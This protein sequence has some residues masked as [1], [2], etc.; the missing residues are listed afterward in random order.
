MTE[1]KSPPPPGEPARWRSSPSFRFV[2]YV[3]LFI[4]RARDCWKFASECEGRIIPT[5][6]CCLQMNVAAK[7]SKQAQCSKAARLARPQNPRPASICKA[8]TAKSLAASRAAIFEA[9][10]AGGQARW[11]RNTGQ[12]S[13]GYLDQPCHTRRAVG[14]Q[15][16]DRHKLGGRRLDIYP[17]SEHL[18]G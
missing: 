5:F 18:Y 3:K 15:I 17:G 9:C 11:L 6:F 14:L 4:T 1:P 7:K 2:R 12:A 13:G 10:L 8:F 16:H